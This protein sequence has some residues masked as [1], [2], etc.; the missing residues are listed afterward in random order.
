MRAT[1]V[2][3]ELLLF[4]NKVRIK[5]QGIG[6]LFLHG[7]KGDKEIYLKNITAIQ[8]KK[9]GNVTSGYIQFSFGGG[10]E[11]K[12]GLWDAVSDENTVM[13]AKQQQ[14]SFIKIKEIIE[15]KIC[16]SE[17]ITQP[18]SRLD[19]LEKLAE[20]R[21]KGIITEEEFTLKKKQILGL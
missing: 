1:G 9:A 16:E 20:L 10:D 11:T 7:F 3:G 5:R 12:D 4:K 21:E 13:F 6:S 14:P 18:S 15:N 19:D 8:L 2:Y 17:G